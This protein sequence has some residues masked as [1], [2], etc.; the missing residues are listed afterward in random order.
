MTAFCVEK[1][2]EKKKEKQKK[3]HYYVLMKLVN[4]LHSEYNTNYTSKQPRVHEL[5]D[6]TE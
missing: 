1:E 3:T 5:V 4:V 6:E 2:K